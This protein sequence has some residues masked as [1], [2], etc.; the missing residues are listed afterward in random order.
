MKFEEKKVKKV[1]M[2]VLGA[3]VAVGASSAIAGVANTKHNLGSTGTGS[4]TVPAVGEICVFCH[5]PHGSDTSAPVPLWNRKLPTGGSFTTYDQLGTAT[6]D[7]IQAQVGSVSLACLSCHDGTQAID[8]VI[9]GPGSGNYNTDGATMSGVYSG[10]SWLT[11][12]TMATAGQIA[13]I[14]QD[15]RNDHPVSIPYGGGG[16]NENTAS[17]AG[18]TVDPDF[19][20]AALN[21]TTS[22]SSAQFWIDTGAIDNVRTST[23]IILYARDTADF[24]GYAGGGSFVPSVECGSCHDPHTEVTTFLRVLNTGSAVCLA[25]HDK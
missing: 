18:T 2:G 22:A 9:N 17:G 11:G 6:F 10:S 21:V 19:K 16:I 8:S 3:A 7:S 24:T 14:G 20:V 25:C 13:Y 5:T 1:V 4:N 23:D 15:L 12:G